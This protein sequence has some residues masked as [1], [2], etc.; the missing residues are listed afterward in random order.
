MDYPLAQQGFQK[1]LRFDF[2]RSS[3]TRGKILWFAWG[4]NEEGPLRAVISAACQVLLSVSYYGEIR[5][6]DMIFQRRISAQ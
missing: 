2:D 3:G 1:S 5:H 4:V 6:S